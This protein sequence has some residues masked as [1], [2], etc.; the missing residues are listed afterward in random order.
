MGRHAS[1]SA[2]PR[3]ADMTDIPSPARSA[4]T[5]NVICLLSML[6]WALGLPAL[7]HL[8]QYLPPLTLTAYRV[9]LAGI[10]LV[11]AWLVWE[12]AG[13]VRRAPWGKG[14]AV[15]FV[16]MGVGAV[17]VAIALEKTD[18]VTVAIITAM[19]PLVGIGLELVLDGRRMTL[20]LL[21]G[22]AL[23]IAGGIVALDL[24]SGAS[25]DLG[26]G[27]L[28]AFGSVFAFTW[29]SRATVTAFPE[30]TPLGRTAITVA[31]A[32]ISMAV[33]AFAYSML[34]G[35]ATDWS[36]IGLPEVA[37]LVAASIGSIALSQ[38]LWI[39]SVGLLGIG[40][41]SL[42]MNAV[43]FYVMLMT[44]AL[45]GAWN[46]AQAIGA[47]IV[48]AGVVVAQGLIPLRRA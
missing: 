8:V 15:G 20:P 6:T 38:T 3:K 12:G 14:I 11:L 23:S 44:F 17:L 40:I 9:G 36:G 1:L 4:L 26:L 48:V 13:T 19:M 37:A 30:L 18:P 46:W 43:P 32:G 16:V 28:A 10:V 25:P 24:G 22:L 45:G 39:V 42:H 2:P 34:G 31:G 21:L 29:G 5:A 35:P 7:S 27:A 41:A 47:A 33:L